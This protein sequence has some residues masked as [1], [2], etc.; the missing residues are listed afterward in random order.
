VS[1]FLAFLQINLCVINDCLADEDHRLTTFVN[2]FKSTT[3]KTN[4]KALLIGDNNGSIRD[5]ACKK[6]SASNT[7]QADIQSARQNDTQ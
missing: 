5:T 3:W 1:C 7:Y 4:K 2:L 6:N